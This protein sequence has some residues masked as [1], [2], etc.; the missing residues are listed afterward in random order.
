[1]LKL[2]E[3]GILKWNV[4]KITTYNI[5]FI[6]VCK[7]LYS[8]DA[9]DDASSAPMSVLVNDVTVDTVSFNLNYESPGSYTN[10]FQRRNRIPL[11]HYD[12]ETVS[13]IIKNEFIDFCTLL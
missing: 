2:P 12:G 10:Q 4:Q 13:N 3:S 9:N 5:F 6:S 11:T 7:R 8:K 1:M